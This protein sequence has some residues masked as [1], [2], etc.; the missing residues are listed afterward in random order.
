MATTNGTGGTNGKI[1]GIGDEAV[2]AKT[3]KTWSEWIATLDKAGARTMEHAEIASLLHEEFGV[4]GWWTQMVTVGYEQSIGK[5]VP[6]QKADGFAA[7]ASK[8]LNV[9]A[10]A[11]FKAFNDPRKRASWL[12]DE[13]T[14]RKATASKSLRITCEDG[15]TNLDVNIYAKSERKTQVSLQHTKLPSAREAA[16][17]KKYWG[18]A[19]KRLEETLTS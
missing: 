2:R 16:R 5:R 8:T 14:I 12:T 13:L 6:R 15:K 9:S 10:A 1:N 18:E 19:L 7:S 3:G 4:P 11:A 17:M